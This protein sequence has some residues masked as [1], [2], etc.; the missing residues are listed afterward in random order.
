MTSQLFLYKHFWSKRENIPLKDIM[1]G[2]VLLKRGAKPGKVCEL[3][4]VSSGPKSIDKALKILR[5]MLK[6]VYSKFYVKNRY[7]CQYCPF[8]DT[9]HCT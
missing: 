8:K 7:S 1:C 4:R 2:F 9:E 6:S 3:V 5:S